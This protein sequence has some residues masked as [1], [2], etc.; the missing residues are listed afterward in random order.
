[1]ADGA[2]KDDETHLMTSKIERRSNYT[3]LF[4]HIPTKLHYHM[5]VVRPPRAIY[6]EA[7]A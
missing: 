1:M 4:K 5:I 3:Q 2:F 7:N 6:V